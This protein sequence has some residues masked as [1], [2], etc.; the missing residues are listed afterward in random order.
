MIIRLLLLCSLFAF[1]ISCND[2]EELFKHEEQT[3][4]LEINE[5]IV[6]H[7]KNQALEKAE[8]EDQSNITE[9]IANS[10]FIGHWVKEDSINPIDPTS[11]FIMKKD[12]TGYSIKFSNEDYFISSSVNSNIIKGTNTCGKFTIKLISETPLVISYSDDGR[13]HFA[14]VVN[15]RF[16]KNIQ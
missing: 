4:I 1:V 7:R 9:P 15:E 16:I 5:E 12:E 14:P 11:F 3:S 13:G 6:E 8:H 2:S 10:I